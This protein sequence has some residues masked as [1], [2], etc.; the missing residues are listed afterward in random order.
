MTGGGTV[1]FA[2]NGTIYLTSTIVVSDDTVLDATGQSV[3]I[4]GSNSV[5]IFI[6]NSNT[7]LAL[8]NLIL[9]DGFIQT[10]LSYTVNYTTSGG[11]AISNAGTLL[12]EGCMFI[13]NSA[14]GLSGNL[15]NGQYG[16]VAS[17]GDGGAIYNSGIVSVNGCAFVGNSV[18]GGNGS[19]GTIG[20]GGAANGGALFN[21]NQ[22][23][24]ANCAFSSNTATGGIGVTEPAGFSDYPSGEAN[25][26]ALCNNGSLMASNNTFALNVAGGGQGGQGIYQDSLYYLYNGGSGGDG[27][28]GAGGAICSVN[29][30]SVLINDT[31]WSNAA[32]GGAAGA[33]AAG[34]NGYPDSEEPG[35]NGGNGGSGGNGIGG[36]LYVSGGSLL[37]LNLTV[38]S[39]SVAGG[40]A[41]AGGPGGGFLEPS[42]S[43]GVAGAAGIAQGDSIGNLGGVVTLKNSILC[44]NA[45]SD[46]NIFGPIVDAGN[47]I[48]SD[49]Q[50]SLTNSTS[51]NGANPGLAPLANNGGPTPTMALLPGSPAIDAADLSDFPATD[52]RG[53]PRPYGPAPDIGAFESTLSV[54]ISGQITGLMPSDQVTVTAGRDSTLTTNDGAYALQVDDTS[55]TIS[56]TNVNYIFVPPEQTISLASNQTGVN[57]QAYRLNAITLGPPSSNSIN[58]AF[59]GTNGQQFRV[60]C[61]ANFTGWTPIATNAI[62]A[63]GYLS[64]SFPITNSGSRFFRL[65]SP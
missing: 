47:N 58:L 15:L 23:T 20:N 45:L 57:F 65:V 14:A 27:N 30:T 21:A 24:F 32:V 54:I 28:A 33:G 53:V 17:D 3:A 2:V 19:S 41:G 6:V 61:S 59:A 7:T 37:A 46:T 40:A 31:F 49:M 64:F 63:A 62:G 60:E 52:Q 13:S 8:T 22:A 29:G 12:M 42:G 56:P 18:L 16:L 25:G 39:N 50:N 10:P 9:R 44:A 11:G 48:D 26:G 38:A 35:G 5:Q 36:A 43:P 51:L 55:F 34:G 4:S 1:T